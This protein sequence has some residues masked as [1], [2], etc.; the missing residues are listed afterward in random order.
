MKNIILNCFPTAF[1]LE[2]FLVAINLKLESKSDEDQLKDVLKKLSSIIIAFDFDLKGQYRSY[3]D[4][5]FTYEQLLYLCYIKIN[6][7]KVASFENHMFKMS[8]SSMNN[9]NS[10]ALAPSTS[11]LNLTN[12]GELERKLNASDNLSILYFMS[13]N[14]DG[15]QWRL[16]HSLI[17]SSI[18]KYLFLYAFMFKQL[19]S[20]PS[21]YVQICGTKFTFVYRSLIS[22]KLQVDEKAI[23]AKSVLKKKSRSNE[24]QSIKVLNN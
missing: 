6:E 19:E 10:G 22:Q 21:T 14:G 17:G 18:M 11:A 13:K 12:Q 23:E 16:L 4:R 8:N 20:A 3:I 5:R 1:S 9:S 15:A 2:S 7:S 24:S